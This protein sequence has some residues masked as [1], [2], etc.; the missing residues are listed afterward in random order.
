MAYGGTLWLVNFW[1]LS[2]IRSVLRSF[3]FLFHRTILFAVDVWRCCFQVGN[4]RL[5]PLQTFCL[6]SAA[7]PFFLKPLIILLPLSY[8]W[9]LGA[10]CEC[11]SHI[12]T[13]SFLVCNSGSCTQFWGPGYK[14]IWRRG[15]PSGKTSGDFEISPGWS[16]GWRTWS[17]SRN[18]DGKGR[19]YCNQIESM[20]RT[21]LKSSGIGHGLKEKKFW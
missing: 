15:K 2:I 17:V 13:A 6:P 9:R 16:R 21:N 7:C 3:G 20:E 5:R 19:S 10:F 1:R 8:C 4:Q 11:R 18:R 14:H 12:D